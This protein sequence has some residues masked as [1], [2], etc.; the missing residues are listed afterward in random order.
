MVAR[1]ARTREQLALATS[2]RNS[3]RSWSEI[4][5][6]LRDRYG[7][8]ARIAIR[9]AH[10]WTQ[11]DAAQQW[12]SRWPDDPKTLK[13]ISYW[14]NWPSPTGAHAVAVRPRSA[15][16]ALR[17]RRCG[18]ARRLERARRR[19]APACGDRARGHRVVTG[20]VT[21]VGSGLNGK[22]PEL[23][24]RL[25]DPSATVVVVEHRDR[26][27]RFGVEHP[28]AA[29][30]AQG[31]RVVVTDPGETSDDLI[32]D[33]I[34]ALT[35]MCARLYGRRGARNRAMRAVTT[36]KHPDPAAETVSEISSGSV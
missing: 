18:P 10:G 25:S 29:L 20:V 9:V 4:A 36:T 11:A 32:R 31:R 22:R 16:P 23:R 35:W 15:C 14:E 13:N 30:S 3:G 7:L 5:G 12:N 34:E 19:T 6:A 8:G 27:A 28:E 2:L 26:L 33:M 1:S 24:R 21:E 17:V